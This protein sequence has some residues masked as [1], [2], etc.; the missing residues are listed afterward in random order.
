LGGF[1]GAIEAL[2]SDEPARKIEYRECFH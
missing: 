1:A 2:H